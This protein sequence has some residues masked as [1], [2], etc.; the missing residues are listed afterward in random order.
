MSVVVTLALFVSSWLIGCG[1]LR[2][3]AWPVAETR[4]AK[5]GT[6]ALAW[7]VGN[8]VTATF[9]VALRSLGVD[10]RVSLVFWELALACGIGV[11]IVSLRSRRVDP[12]APTLHV[13]RPRYL[14]A[15]VVSI[16]LI[17]ILGACVG[18]CSCYVEYPEGRTDAWAIWNLAARF[19]AA[20]GDA[21]TGQFNAANAHPDYPLLVP[22]ALAR[23]WRLAG[24]DA[25]IIAA[26][27]LHVLFAASLC[28]LFV[29][30]LARTRGV[31]V[32]LLAGAMLLAPSQFSH[33][34]AVLY[35]DLPLASFFLAAF[36]V[37][38]E[39]ERRGGANRCWAL[40]GMLAAFAAWTKNEG[41]VFLVVV[42]AAIAWSQRRVPH[43]R[44][45]VARWALGAAPVVLLIATF[46]VFLMPANDLVAGYSHWVE[47]VAVPAR[48]FAIG[49]GLLD[50][51]AL[52]P[53]A[54]LLL[55]ALVVGVRP[56]RG[57]TAQAA[58]KTCIAM[59]A[60][61]CAVYLTTPFDL[62]THL[63][64]SLPRL[65]LQLWPLALWTIFNTVNWDRLAPGTAGV[66]PAPAMAKYARDRLRRER[67]LAR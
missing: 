58:T 19:L 55:I 24:G 1:L 65:L 34:A 5:L 15:G 39:A 26:R 28:G 47:K 31:V 48:Y 60:V 51:W 23:C 62:A 41:I 56:N 32:A 14:L 4:T 38:E 33:Y 45:L 30:S 61:F 67:R 35:A 63:R 27:A 17:T 16:F 43:G 52:R 20:D 50:S 11:T 6:A 53:V 22:G 64:T 36:V 49:L 44:R 9:Y 40:A 59:L 66:P 46:K 8:A 18:V 57:A 10:G 12:L 2:L 3:F 7:L 29:A 13:R 42:G 37:M 21:W 54:M 25:S